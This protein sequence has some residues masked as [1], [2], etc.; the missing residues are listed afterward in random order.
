[1]T[2]D[3]VVNLP[4]RLDSERWRQKTLCFYSLG[5]EHLELS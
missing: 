3:I 1:M 4:L 5:H 2:K